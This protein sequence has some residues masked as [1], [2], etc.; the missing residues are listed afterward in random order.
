M[1]GDTSIANRRAPPSGQGSSSTGALAPL[2][3]SSGAAAV[4]AARRAPSRRTTRCGPTST[5][6]PAA[7][8][9]WPGETSCHV[10]ADA[11]QAHPSTISD[12]QT[13]S[14]RE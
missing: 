1:T 8:P 11:L 9:S 4:S 5:R 7:G 3:N 2:V 6:S 14:R 10:A 13:P 12:V